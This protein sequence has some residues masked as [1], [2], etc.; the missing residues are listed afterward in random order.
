MEE[1]SDSIGWESL[2]KKAQGMGIAD[3][4][5]LPRHELLTLIGGDDAEA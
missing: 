4:H 5:L 2:V 3:A 1:D